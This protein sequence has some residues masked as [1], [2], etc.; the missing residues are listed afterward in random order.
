MLK[1]S[2][3]ISDVMS[4]SYQVVANNISNK[5]TV[6]N[7]N[8]FKSSLWHVAQQVSAYY[9]LGHKWQFN[10][11]F[12]HSYNEIGENTDVKMFFGD[13]GVSYKHRSMELDVS[14]NN[15]FNNHKYS[16]SLYNGLD[17]FDYVYDLRPRMLMLTMSY[18]Y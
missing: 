1:V 12:E 14:L 11:L 5:I 13:I 6:S 4:V 17:R 3:K 16:Y 18:R 10:S 15:I 9:K 7:D 2:V 8:Q